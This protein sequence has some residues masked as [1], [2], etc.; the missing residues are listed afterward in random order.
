MRSIRLELI[1]LVSFFLVACS[2]GTD[3]KEGAPAGDTGGVIVVQALEKELSA[4]DGLLGELSQVQDTL[5][6]Q[7]AQLKGARLDKRLPLVKLDGAAI[8]DSLSAYSKMHGLGDV[9]VKLGKS[10]PAKALPEA[11][12]GGEVFPYERKHLVGSAPIAISVASN[13]EARLKTFF[14]AM[15]KLQLP[16]MVLP[17]LLLDG[18]RATFSGSVYFRHLALGPKRA[19]A[20]PTLEALCKERG[21]KLPSEDKR[22]EA[23][24]LHAQLTSKRA[25]IATLMEDKDTIARQ[26]RVLQF[27]RN[28]DKEIA[29]QSVPKLVK[30]A[31]SETPSLSPKAGAAP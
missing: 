19:E 31:P 15:V 21:L 22:S 26:A 16:L 4:L 12:A 5:K 8:R 13:D 17:T 9:Q 10:D 23:Q 29:S 18:Q 28:K 24:S 7:E 1:V 2:K 27:L 11:F 20:T 14:R 25:S 6:R 30:K 3:E